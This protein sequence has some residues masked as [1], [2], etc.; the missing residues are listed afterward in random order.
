MVV[1]W[2]ALGGWLMVGV[3][4]DTSCLKTGNEAKAMGRTWSIFHTN[5]A[6]VQYLESKAEMNN[7]S[8]LVGKFSRFCIF[9]KEVESKETS[10]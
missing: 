10:S 8:N 4:M 7:W 9:P 3:I 1:K 6:K 5:F 2:P